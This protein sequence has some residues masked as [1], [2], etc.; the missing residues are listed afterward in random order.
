MNGPKGRS[1]VDGRSPSSQSVPVSQIATS[2]RRADLDWIRVAALGLLILYHVGLVFA[3]WDWHVH[4]P[5]YVEEL[6]YAALAMNPWRLT[7]L[8]LV[9]GAAVRLMSR[10]RTAG[11]V[12]KGRAARLL[13]PLAFGV[14]VL[15]P[16]QSWIEAVEKGS[17]SAGLGAWWLREF[18]L[19]GVANGV[20]LNHLW[21]VLYITAYSLVAVALL[22]RPRWLAA[23]ESLLVR[24]LSGWRLLVLPVIYLAVVRQLILPWVGVTNQIQHDWYNHAVSL[25]AF[26][27]GF[28][29][30]DR[31]EVWAAL[32]RARFKA[33]AL[34]AV[35]LPLLIAMEM[36]PGGRAFGGTVKNA[37]FALDQWATIAAILGFASVHLRRAHSPLLGYLNQ[38]IFPCY[39]AHQTVLVLAAHLTIH[40]NLPPALEALV[41]VLATLGGSLL[42]YEAVRRIDLIRPLWGLKRLGKA[43]SAPQAADA[44][45]TSAEPA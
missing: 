42:V 33:L 22:H 8:F 24:G 32:E 41:L 6:G 27:L 20:P 34:A 10:R 21:F 9:S 36:H 35:A 2:A 16:P 45:A 19:T 28:A 13:P 15:V 7:L 4:S 3:P 1:A 11:A 37:V 43:T 31:A 44:S 5:H 38:A 14:L 29:V 17:W 30:A 39:L 26:L 23:L 40:R 18:S 25:I 12:L